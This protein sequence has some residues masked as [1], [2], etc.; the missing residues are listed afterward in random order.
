MQSRY[1]RHTCPCSQFY[2]QWRKDEISCQLIAPTTLTL[3]IPDQHIFFCFLSALKGFR[4][5]LLCTKF[6]RGWGGTHV[7]NI[8]IFIF[9]V[10]L[11]SIL[12]IRL[13]RVW[14]L[15]IFFFTFE[16]PKSVG[17]QHCTPHKMMVFS[18]TIFYNAHDKRHVILHKMHAPKN[19][20]EMWMVQVYPYLKSHVQP[21]EIFY[22]SKNIFE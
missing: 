12:Q 21:S 8:W 3:T 19:I 7:A 6:S 17:V 2:Y 13:F 10:G 5:A 4:G 22:K 14:K 9:S 20:R 18:R 11:H 1:Q 16:N 15:E